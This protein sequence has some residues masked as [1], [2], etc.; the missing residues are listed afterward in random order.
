M[1]TLFK[2][3]RPYPLPANPD[4]ARQNGKSFL[5]EKGKAVLYPLTADG[6][7]C[8]KPAAKWAANVRLANGTRKRFRFSPNRDAS[9][10]ML[11]DLL[12][13]IENEKAGVVDRFA[14]HRKRPLAGHIDD[15]RGS[16]AASD[17]GEE[18]ITLKLTRV[19]AVF[20]KCGFVLPSDLT[21]DRLE[22]FLRDLRVKEK[23][24]VQTS[25][26]WLQAVRQF[27]RW[28][29]AKAMSC[30]Q[31]PI[32]LVCFSWNQRGCARA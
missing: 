8:L 31:R 15:W 18:Y 17:R 11:A 27:C 12:R 22:T 20:D 7:Q 29:I 9:A 6:K 21:A 24:S 4:I 23:R 26:D 3:D 5:R 14:D 25:N 1:A 16:L 10:E 28:M 2:P 19:R 13:K 30:W 32:R